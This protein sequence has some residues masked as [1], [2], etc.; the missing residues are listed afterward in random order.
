MRPTTKM[1]TIL[2]PPGHKSRSKDIL[3]P[4]QIASVIDPQMLKLIAVAVKKSFVD[5]EAKTLLPAVKATRGKA[6]NV[7]KDRR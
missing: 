1:E 7:V 4:I 2:N 6:L 5:T 3:Q